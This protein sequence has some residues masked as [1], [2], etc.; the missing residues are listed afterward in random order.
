MSYSYIKEWMFFLYCTLS[1]YFLSVSFST[2]LSFSI[3]LFDCLFL[4]CLFVC[5]MACFLF[6]YLFVWLS[7]FYLSIWMLILKIFKKKAKY[8]QYTKALGGRTK[9]KRKTKVRSTL[10]TWIFQTVVIHT[11][12]WTAVLSNLRDHTIPMRNRQMSVF[13]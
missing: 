12:R 11:I 2:L 9:R 10:H 6:V 5:L 8:L 4:N 13:L 3:C 1:L 7:V